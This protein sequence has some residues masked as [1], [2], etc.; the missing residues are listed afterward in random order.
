MSY[1]SA[2]AAWYDQLTQEVDYPGRAAYFDQIIRERM[3][4][5][6]ETILL[7]LACGTGNLSREMAQKGYDVIGVDG[8]PDMLAEAMSKPITQERPILYL[9]QEM[10]QLD[11]YGTVDVTI[12]AL[13]SLNHIT[14]PEEVKQVLGKVSLFTVPGGLFVFD[15]NT[16]YKHQQVLANHTFVYDLDQVY[17]VWQNTTSPDYLTEI[18]L[19]LFHREGDAY[20][21]SEE[22]FYERG[23]SHEWLTQALTD[24]GMELLAVYAGDTFEPV[25]ED[26]QRAVYV[27]RKL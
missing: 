11:L 16:L 1:T 22:R 7:D 14:D 21:R 8:S 18:S 17:C 25:K 26:T 2:F 20:Y 13:D 4:V 24:T 19:D 15:V 23:Y 6:Q 5:T 27:A 3:E 12:C 9:C 10:A